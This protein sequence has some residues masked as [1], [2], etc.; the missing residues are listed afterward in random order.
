MLLMSF[1]FGLLQAAAPEQV[2]LN[3][4]LLGSSNAV[5]YE[6]NNRPPCYRQSISYQDANLQLMVS[7]VAMEELPRND[8][9]KSVSFRLPI[10]DWLRKQLDIV[11]EFVTDNVDLASLPESSSNKTFVYKP[12]WRGPQMYVSVSPRCDFQCYDSATG[13]LQSSSLSNMRGK[14]TYTF[15][16]S[17][18][19]IYIGPHKK[20]E[21]YSLSL[22]IV[23][24]IFYPFVDPTVIPKKPVKRRR[25]K[26]A[27]PVAQVAVE[28]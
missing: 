3:P 14:G 27:V 15:T 11:E 25:Q 18:P 20:G 7:N 17:V 26:N 6:V 1:L 13:V 22:E 28:A 16:L 24:I 21:D 10:T 8:F 23:Q 4:T 12:L 19:F 5:R 2:N 9:G